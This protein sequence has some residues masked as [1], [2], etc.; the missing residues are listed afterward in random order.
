[1]QKKKLKREI[2]VNKKVIKPERE[3]KTKTKL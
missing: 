3:L 2:I 1:M